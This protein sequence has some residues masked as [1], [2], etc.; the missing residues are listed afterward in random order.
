MYVSSHRLM[1]LQLAGYV[2]SRGGARN[3]AST[4]II[5][6]LKDDFEQLTRYKALQ[7]GEPEINRADQM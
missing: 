2:Q 1:T 4:L 5:M 3:K 6:I 7:E